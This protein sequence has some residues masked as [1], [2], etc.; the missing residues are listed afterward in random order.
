MTDQTGSV[1]V[2]T[3]KNLSFRYPGQAGDCLSGIGFSIPA[4]SV[5][6]LLGPSGAGKT[7]TQK[8]L[9]GLLPKYRGDVAVLGSPARAMGSDVRRRVGVAFENPALYL[10]FSGIENLRFFSALMH[11]SD[12]AYRQ[13]L[14]YV[15]LLDLDRDMDKRVEH[16]SRGMRVRMNLCRALV[17]DP[18]LIYLD[19]PTAGLDP[20]LAKRVKD[21]IV[22]L[23]RAG[24]TIVLT[25]HIM[26]LAEEVCDEL[27]IIVGGIVPA[28][29]TPAALQMKYG[30]PFVEVE[31]SGSTHRF[32]LPG[33]GSNAGFLDLLRRTEVR[34]IRTLEA[35]MEQV[36]LAVSGTPMRDDQDAYDSV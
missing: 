30:E 19:E 4:G 12:S 25:T 27:G 13:A 28:L 31:G 36:F 22:N 10:K 14:E 15:R 6:G 7:T 17:H 32:P 8:I 1:P 33:L 3:V 11:G 21:L 34:R 29:D 2:V 20:I 16:Y 24:K 9:M 18:D 35:S 5:F 26:S 23:K